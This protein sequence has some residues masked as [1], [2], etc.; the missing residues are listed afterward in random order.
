[1]TTPTELIPGIYILPL[2][3]VNAFLINTGR[4]LVLVDTGSPGNA[5]RLVRA[6]QTLGH[7]VEEIQHI[8]ITEAS[9]GICQPR[10]FP[11]LHRAEPAGNHAACVGRARAARRR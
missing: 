6:V 9:A 10:P 8:L 1:M 11:A 3:V 7:R 2:G 5:E 4:E